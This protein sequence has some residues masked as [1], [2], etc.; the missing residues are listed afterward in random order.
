MDNKELKDKL[1]FRIA[2]SELDDEKQKEKNIKPRVINKL[3]TAA[4]FVMLIGGIAYAEEI[5]KKV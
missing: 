1:K 4:C 5:S 3:V 2:M